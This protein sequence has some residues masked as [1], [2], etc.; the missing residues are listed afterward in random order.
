MLFGIECMVDA[1]VNSGENWYSR[2]SEL[3]SPRQEYHNLTLVP[4]RA[5]AQVDS[6]RF[7]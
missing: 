6:F 7:E 4:A 2:P 1:G 5:L 3:V